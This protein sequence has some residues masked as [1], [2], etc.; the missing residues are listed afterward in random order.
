[1][2]NISS[3]VMNQ[4]VEPKDSLDDFPT[5][6]WATRALLEHVLKFDKENPPQVW[7]PACNRGYMVRP[8]EEYT[9]DVYASDVHNYGNNPV[10]DFLNGT[11]FA[12]HKTDWVITNPPF[13][14]AQAF[15]E[16]GLY[17]A[18]QG[19][20]ILAKTTFLEGKGRYN[21]LF[22]K[23]PPS[24]IAQFSERVTRVKGRVDPKISSATAY[25][26]FVWFKDTE[27]KT[28]QMVWIP[29]CR[30]ELEKENDFHP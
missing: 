18:T 4:R 28:T 26:W 1:M 2:Q 11:E 30:K 5:P 6:P 21:T 8:L 19:V 27:D 7:E 23:N 20:A 13:N 12:E 3:A 29:P 9:D 24:V 14:K 15:I 10:Y 17:T 16:K 22:S 25:A